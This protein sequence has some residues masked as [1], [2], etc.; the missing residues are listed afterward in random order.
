MQRV[1]TSCGSVPGGVPVSVIVKVEATAGGR[2]VFRRSV[3][4]EE[5]VRLLNENGCDA[6][7]GPNGAVVLSEKAM[8]QLAAYVPEEK[9]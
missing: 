7:L 1:V 8:E 3:S 9:P 4:A 6:S 2:F 5:T